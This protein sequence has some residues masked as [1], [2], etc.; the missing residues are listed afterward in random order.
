SPGS[1]GTTRETNTWHPSADGM[2]WNGFP[3]TSTTV[4]GFTPACSHR[5]G[6]SGLGDGA[7]AS[8]NGA[9]AIT[10]I[11]SD[12][13]PASPQSIAVD[14]FVRVAGPSPEFAGAPLGRQ[15]G[16]GDQRRW[17]ARKPENHDPL[18]RRRRFDPVITRTTSR[19]TAIVVFISC[20]CR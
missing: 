7:Q 8:D 13:C 11:A 3:G 19:R 5:A 18:V 1:T 20:A 15:H 9:I 2:A 12:D 16:R 17:S 4:T 10:T 6:L 14:L